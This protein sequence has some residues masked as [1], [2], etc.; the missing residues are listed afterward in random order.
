MTA[1]APDWLHRADLTLPP[2]PM[3][4]EPAV[5]F[6][7]RQADLA[8]IECRFGCKS[9]VVGVFHTPQGCVCWPDPIQALCAQHANEAQ[10]TGPIVCVLDFT[11]YEKVC[12]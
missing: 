2:A 6:T 3:S 11:E 10:S 1:H 5:K 7:V 9:P 4:G 12:P 8:A